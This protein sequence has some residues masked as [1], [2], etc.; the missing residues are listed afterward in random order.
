MS[1]RRAF[2][3]V[4]C[5][6]LLAV[7]ASAQVK[8]EYK[9]PEKTNTR[10]KTVVR[11]HQ[12]MTI[13]G[14]EIET[15]AEQTITTAREIGERDKDGNLPVKQTVEALQAMFSLPG[16]QNFS[17]DSA[18]P[19][20]K[21][22]NEQLAFL[23]DALKAMIGASYT[24]VL[25]EKG[26][27]KFVQGTEQLQARMADLNP[28]AAAQVR[29]QL[30]AETLRKQFQEDHSN[31]P[32]VLARKGEPWERTTERPLGGSQ[33]FTFRERFE[34][35]GTVEKD[36]KSLDKISSKVLD[37]KFAMGDNP[38]SP[39]KVTGSDIQ[40]ESSSGT[41]LFDREAGLPV[42]RSST[43]RLKGTLKMSIN[44]QELPADLDLTIDT[45][46]TLAPQSK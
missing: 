31:L 18:N 37:A 2:G 10:W 12:I 35:E 43:V 23:V 6:L 3:S 1:G 30:E 27:A 20:A 45:T 19:D 15:G 22:D 29:D 28:L 46:Q 17:F 7:P 38:S 25:D 41:I 24:I 39:V 8:L 9:F 26:Q 14:M 5:F 42:E 13:M 21:P 34:Y 33:T 16:N 4:A 36:G 40:V 44:G 11:T 32:E